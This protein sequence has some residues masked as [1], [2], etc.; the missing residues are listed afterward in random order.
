MRIVIASLLLVI[1]ALVV[2]RC[3]LLFTFITVMMQRFGGVP[4]SW[5]FLAAN[6]DWVVLFVG[7]LLS[8]VVGLF[9]LRRRPRPVSGQ[10]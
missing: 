9:M 3:I 8:A 10:D 1:G 2:I 6:A 7:G 4:Y 5:N